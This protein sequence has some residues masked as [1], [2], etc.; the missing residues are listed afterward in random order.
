MK[1]IVCILLV[2]LV[3]LGIFFFD[4][5]NPSGNKNTEDYFYKINSIIKDMDFFTAKAIDD[6]IVLY[7]AKQKMIKEIPF[8][9]YDDNIKF[10]YARKEGSVIYFIISLAIDDEQGIMFIN[11]DS[12]GLLDGIKTINRVG[13][14]SYGYSTN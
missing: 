7:N 9:D 10:V 12:N 4:F 6:K 2:F 11:D 1:K 13:G 8:E 14:N 5:Y 3:L